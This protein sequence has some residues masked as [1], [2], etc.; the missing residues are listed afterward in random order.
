[1]PTLKRMTKREVDRLPAPDPSGKQVLWFDPELKGFG[2]LVS[3]VS[4]QKSYIVQRKLPDGKTRRVTV[5]SVAE[6]DLDTARRE[7][8]ELLHEIRRGRDPKARA[9][10]PATLR[11]ALDD[12]LAAN[13]NLKP[14]TRRGYRDAVERWLADWLDRPLSEVT[15]AAAE[16]RHAEIQAEVEERRRERARRAGRDL[17]KPEHWGGLSGASTANGVMRALRAIWNHASDGPNPVRLRRSWFN[18]PRRERTVSAED[19]PRFYR[20]LENCENTIA[21]DAIKLML[22]TGLRRGE[23]LALRWAEIDLAVRVIRL[24]AG[25]T[26]AGRRLD[27]PLSSHVHA[28]LIGRRAAGEDGPFVFPADS[29]SGHLEE[30][31]A[32]LGPVAEATGIEISAH[33]LRRV[34][35][36]VAESTDI[37]YLALKALVNHSAGNDVTAGYARLSLERLRGPA[38]KVGDKIAELCEIAVPEGEN[39][40]R[41]GEQA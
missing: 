32:A 19:L 10:A 16:K 20:A 34:Y 30:P 39:V 1:M 22:F 5:G 12:Y 24:P 11:R 27:L 33:D 25:R 3:G 9:A 37:S 31:R 26:K 15:R 38:Q 13:K 36:T 8:A 40:T 23:A 29:R 21:R 18:E 7:A 41:I 17:V 2:V 14:K 28:L 35:V 6:V 4:N